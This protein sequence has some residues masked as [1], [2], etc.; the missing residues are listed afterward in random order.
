[1][2]E[3]GGIADK[4]E[5]DFLRAQWP[6]L[7]GTCRQMADAMRFI[8]AAF[9]FKGTGIFAFHHFPLYRLCAHGC[10]P[11]YRLPPT[12]EDDML[13]D[14]IVRLCGVLANRGF[15]LHTRMDNNQPLSEAGL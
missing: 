1:M 15:V 10:G 13:L 9:H 4:H 5:H 3:Q 11:S 2:L 7:K 6:A 8:P 14:D 12:K